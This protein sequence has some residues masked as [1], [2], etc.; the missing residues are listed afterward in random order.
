MAY[1][2]SYCPACSIERQTG[3]QAPPLAHGWQAPTS[4]QMRKA[5]AWVERE[6]PEWLNDDA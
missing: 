1:D 6:H 2:P 4:D 3:E 5:Q